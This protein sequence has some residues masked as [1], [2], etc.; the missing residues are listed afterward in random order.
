[1][2]EGTDGPRAAAGGLPDRDAFD[3][4][5]V[6]YLN[7]AYMGPLPRRAVEAGRN[8]LERK[9]RPWEIGVP[10]F[11]EPLE[12]ARSLFAHLVGGDADGVCIVPSVSYGIALAAANLPVSRGQTIVVL[13]EQFPSNVYGWRDACCPRRGRGGYRSSPS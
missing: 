1:M 5:G 11:F 12:R 13:S 6:A 7:C 9:A 8:G 2:I 4:A 3:L 10:D